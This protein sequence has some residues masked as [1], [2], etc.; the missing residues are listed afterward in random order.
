MSKLLTS[1]HSQSARA[2]TFRGG[3]IMKRN[4]V[5]LSFAVVSVLLGGAQAEEREYND[6]ISGTAAPSSFDFNG[7]FVPAHYVTFSGLSSLGPV[8]GAYLVEYDFLA[9]APDPACPAGTLKLPIIVS[10]S[11]RA[12]QQGGQVFLQDD[13]ASAL[14]CLNPDVG[15][16]TMSLKGAFIGGMGEFAGATG[17]YEYQ[18]SGQVL[19]SDS[20]MLPFGGFVLKTVGKLNVPAEEVPP[21]ASESPVAVI[22]P[23][24]QTVVVRE[25]QLDGSQ[26]FDPA[27]DPITYSWE[28]TGRPAALMHADTAT[29]IV[30]FGSGRGDYTFELTVTNNKG[31]SSK[32][33][34]TVVYVGL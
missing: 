4:T 1:E 17:T 11:I 5:V 16:F 2:Q 24:Q 29:P 9:L 15:S 32:K 13:T 10:S 28:V 26:S 18:G 7:D 6:E 20:K 12:T 14:F 34:T 8:H 25:I 33:T 22:T 3:S 21:P 27:G 19:L 31:L 30:Q 23:D